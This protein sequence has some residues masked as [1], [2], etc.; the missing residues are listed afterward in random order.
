MSIIRES[1]MDFGPFPD[2]RVFH[3][4]KSRLYENMSGRSVKSVEFMWKKSR[5]TLRFVEAKSSSPQPTAENNLRFD[6]FINDVSDKFLHSLNLYCSAVL[7][8]HKT[9]CDLPEAFRSL[10]AGCT[11][12]LF[13]LVINGHQTEWLPPI[14]E[15]LIRKL[16]PYNAIWGVEI[17]VF[18]HEMA[19]EKGLIRKT[20]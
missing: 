2:D 11:A 9:V 6:D 10:N 15:A 17:A 5:N 16:R 12:I 7:E 3:I 18:N 4:E 19:V 8:R 14:R 13:C 1:G 20:A